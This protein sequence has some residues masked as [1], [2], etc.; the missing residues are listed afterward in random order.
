MNKSKYCLSSV[1]ILLILLLTLNGCATEPKLD[2]KSN[3]P[4]EVIARSICEDIY[5]YPVI[6]RGMWNNLNVSD[7]VKTLCT[8]T[9]VFGW[10]PNPKSFF[11]LPP[12]PLALMT[13]PFV[14]LALGAT[15]L[16]S[17]PTLDV[18][19]VFTHPDCPTVPKEKEPKKQG[20]K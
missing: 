13:I 4:P 1:I 8:D 19:M 14:S 15:S 5:R 16:V 17:L 10:L 20:T 9:G 7:M 3:Q 18:I 11:L 6:T 2:L 12:C